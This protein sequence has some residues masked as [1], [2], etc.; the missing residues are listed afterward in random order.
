[1]QVKFSRVQV[2][3]EVEDFMQTKGNDTRFNFQA[4]VYDLVQHYLHKFL[5]AIKS[6][7]IF[8]ILYLQIGFLGH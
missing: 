5:H 6:K 8:A 2:L 7:N 4:K 1:M 3:E